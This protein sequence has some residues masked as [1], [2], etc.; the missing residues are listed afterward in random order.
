[1]RYDNSMT[2]RLRVSS[3]AI[4][5][6]TFFSLGTPQLSFADGRGDWSG[7]AWQKIEISACAGLDTTIA[8][9]VYHQ[10][11]D[12]K[13]NQWVDITLSLDIA[14]DEVSLSQRLTNND[15]SDRDHVC[16]TVLV[17]DGTGK[18]LI[19]HHQNW[20]IGSGDVVQESFAYTSPALARAKT[21]HIGSKQCRNG[22][23][24]DDATYAKVL[25]KIGD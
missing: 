20:Q 10:K 4:L 2:N 22:G 9:P 17:V 15:R 16:V 5:I 13:R 3:L 11:W 14:T 19:A 1:M 7:Y 6:A 24:E 23:S 21:I 18:D 8:C 12:W 25:A